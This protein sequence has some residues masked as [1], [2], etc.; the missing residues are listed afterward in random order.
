VRRRRPLHLSQSYALTALRARHWSSG[1]RGTEYVEGLDFNVLVALAHSEAAFGRVKEQVHAQP[2]SPLSLRLRHSWAT[3]ALQA[4][5]P[6]PRSSASAWA[7]AR[8]PSRSTPTATSPRRGKQTR[9]RW[10][11]LSSPGSNSGSKRGCGRIPGGL[12]CI[13]LVSEGG[14][15]PPR[16]CGHQ[17]LKL[18]RLPIPPL[19]RGCPDGQVTPRAEDNPSAARHRPR[20]QVPHLTQSGQD[21]VTST[22]ST[23]KVPSSRAA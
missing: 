2:C 9:P 1:G 12:T 22:L 19:R 21:P 10:W 13:F 23:S 6:I 16:P 11:P 14:L 8:S 20:T 15:E 3:L 5:V 7:T 18:A 4:G 17:P